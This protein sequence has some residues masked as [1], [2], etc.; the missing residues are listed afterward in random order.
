MEGGLRIFKDLHN[1]YGT[2]GFIAAGLIAIF[3]SVAAVFAPAYGVIGNLFVNLFII[4]YTA[5][6]SMVIT[7]VSSEYTHQAHTQRLGKSSASLS[8]PFT[9]ILAIHLL[10]LTRDARSIVAYKP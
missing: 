6:L 4:C 7:K 1:K 5:F 8:S 2:L 9:D 10:H 3:L